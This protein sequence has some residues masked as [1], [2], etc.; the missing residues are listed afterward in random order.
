[1]TP[2]GGQRTVTLC[3]VPVFRA[4]GGTVPTRTCRVRSETSPLFCP[5]LLCLFLFLSLCPGNSHVPPGLTRIPG[6][7]CLPGCGVLSERRPRSS[8]CSATPGSP[9]GTLECPGSYLTPGILLSA[10]HSQPHGTP[11]CSWGGPHLK[12][13][14][15]PDCISWARTSSP[16]RLCVPGL[17]QLNPMMRQSKVPLS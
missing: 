2:P 15:H 9:F 8:W 16:T 11:A 7:W 6:D 13:S 5:E 10:A 4:R 1:M 17:D 14:Q 12:L 3:A